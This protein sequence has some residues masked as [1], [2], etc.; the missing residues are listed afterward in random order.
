MTTSGS[1][2]A[3]R[4]HPG[5]W[6]VVLAAGVL[7]AWTIRRPGYSVTRGQAAAFVGSLVAALV[8]LT[9]PLAD[10]AATRSLTALVLQRLLLL[11]AVPPLALIGLPDQALARLTR[12]AAV[13][14]VV[15]R[16]SQPVVAIAVVTVIAVGTLTTGAVDAQA[17]SWA[18][19]ATLDL[20]LVVAGLVLWLP[21]LGRVPG[22]DRPSALGRGGYLI[23]QSIVPSFLAVVWIFA[24]HP[25]YPAYAHPGTVAGL[26]PLLDQQIAGFTAKLGTIFVL[27]TV[28]F[29]IINRSE[30]REEADAEPLTWADVERRLQRAERQRRRGPGRGRGGGLPRGPGSSPYDSPPPWPE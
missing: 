8:A 19:R 2:W 11:L 16:A 27:W 3:L 12:P 4:L 29:V 1:P 28:A 15:Q 18:A 21:V 23:V 13:D 17:T 26:S 14:T 10:L 5:A 6:V 24:R 9:W 20:V 30:R 25:L 7:Y 22:I